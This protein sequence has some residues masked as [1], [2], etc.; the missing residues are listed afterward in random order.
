MVPMV[1][2]S[3]KRGETRR[4]PLVE[5]RSEAKGLSLDDYDPSSQGPARRE[6]QKLHRHTR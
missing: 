2:G 4:L 5:K 6:E 1:I 3:E